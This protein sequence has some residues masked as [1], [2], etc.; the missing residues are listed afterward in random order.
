MFTTDGQCVRIFADE[1]EI[2]TLLMTEKD[3]TIISSL[4]N[5]VAILE[6]F[7]DRVVWLTIESVDVSTLIK[8]S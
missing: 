5:Q 2:K 8:R 7:L 3:A 6:S 1:T 4:N